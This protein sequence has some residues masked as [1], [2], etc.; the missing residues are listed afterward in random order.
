MHVKFVL[1]IYIYW[2][3]LLIWVAY[4]CMYKYIFMKLF[5]ILIIYMIYTYHVH[6]HKLNIHTY[7]IFTYIHIT[8]NV[9]EKKGTHTSIYNLINSFVLWYSIIIVTKQYITYDATFLESC[10]DIITSENTNGQ[11][12][13]INMHIY[14]LYIIHLYMI[15][16]I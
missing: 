9:F 2:Y 11:V 7:Y 13:H 3:T 8:Q 6:T 5:T 1:F 15:V 12:I 10:E 16:K 14:T 4:I